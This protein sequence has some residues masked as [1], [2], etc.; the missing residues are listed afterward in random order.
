MPTF[1]F[2]NVVA[3]RINL[4]TTITGT[5]DLGSG[6]ISAPIISTSSIDSTNVIIFHNP[7][8]NATEYSLE[9]FTPDYPQWIMYPFSPMNITNGRIEYPFTLS[10]DGTYV[11][12]VRAK[13]STSTS[14]YS[15]ESQ[16]TKNTTATAT[17]TLTV[18]KSVYLI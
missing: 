4:T 12:R 8:S 5:V 9:A 17:I 2:V 18:A 6:S 16:V 1:S 14:L 15:N 11:F 7:V 10:S 13:N 3:S